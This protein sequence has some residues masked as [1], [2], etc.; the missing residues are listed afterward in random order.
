MMMPKFSFVEYLAKTKKIPWT[1][2]PM[3]KVYEMWPMSNRMINYIRYIRYQAL[4]I[5]RK[6]NDVFQLR[7]NKKI[8]DYEISFEWK[9][10]FKFQ[11]VDDDLFLP[12]YQNIID[13]YVKFGKGL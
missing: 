13:A 8:D 9:N 2:K 4:R 5:F 7:A 10:N 1:T 6:P 12:P 3:E 11:L